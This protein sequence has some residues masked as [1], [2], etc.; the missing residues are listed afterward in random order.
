MSR[1][2]PINVV[3]AALFA[4]IILTFSF[5]F[6]ISAMTDNT[7]ASE[8]VTVAD[9]M[10]F[11]GFGESYYC[12]DDLQMLIGNIEYWL[13][14][15]I[16]S[17]DIILGENGFLFDAGTEDNGYNYL[18]D[19]I[20]DATLSGTEL[21]ALK[22]IIDLR[23][24]VYESRGIDYLLVV[25]PNAQTVYSDYMPDYMGELSENTRLS[26]LTK[27][28]EQ[29]GCDYF[30]NATE[31]LLTAKTYGK[32]LYNN[33][34]NSLNSL[35]EWY[36]YDAVRQRLEQLYGIKGSQ[37][38]VSSLDLYTR[39]TDGKELA[40]RAGLSSVIF[41]ETLSLSNSAQTKYTVSSYYGTMVHSAITE[42]YKVAGDD[43]VVLLEFSSEWDRILL[44]P[45][46]SNTYSQVTYKDNHQFSR[47]AVEHMNPTVVVQFVH[48]HE[49]YDLLDSNTLLTYSSGLQVSVQ[50]DVTAPPMLIAQSSIDEN[51]VCVAG[52]TEYGAL[53]K[54][55]VD[56][57]I[58]RNDYAVG[59]L[60]FI[61]VDLGERES[62]RVKIT[63]QAQ[64]KK[65]SDA[66]E[67]TL[68]RD[69][70]AKQKTVAVGTNSELYSSDYS[71]LSF[72][73]DEQMLSV[74]E[75][76][77]Q[78]VSNVKQLTG[79][80]TEYIYLIVPDKLAVYPDD[81]PEE[82]QQILPTLNKYR[83]VVRG[84]RESAGMTVI[85]LTKEMRNHTALARLYSQTD[86]L[87]TGFGAYVGYH[88][89][90]SRVA[91]RFSAVQVHELI[92][93]MAAT[94]QNV[95]GELVSRL[96][97]DGAVIS[98]SYLT[99]QRSFQP[100]ARFE[101][102]GDGVLDLTQAFI[103]YTDNRDLPV[104][105]VVRDEYGTEMLENIAE[106]FSKMIVLRE[107]EFT[108]SDELIAEIKPDYIINIRCNGE[109]S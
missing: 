66:I 70:G 26:V 60:F 58:I 44:M 91:E 87:W 101:H 49:I 25:V 3:C 52:E 7:V 81:A 108:V 1:A 47:L 62:V 54:V 22:S 74:R 57:E 89:L 82:L 45:Y 90:A 5:F 105:I 15:S 59:E 6:G 100:Q 73:S 35:G 103:S 71:W 8:T 97:L 11:S 46:F 2:K 31:T 18:R 86:V 30:F 65:V 102:S 80:D 75:G 19:Y 4:G 17:P 50:D 9:D 29:V 63:A 93:F 14:G 55:S 104:A 51:T 39:S 33:T 72:L 84:V 96:G 94:E 16:D 56:G 99:L 21:K 95:G 77:E 83:D 43:N 41:N 10:T 38:G 106:H 79:K 109:L 24:N 40:R 37:V 28:L 68:Y 98:E 78:K 13:F 64:G 48:E 34:E 20:G 61:P 27:Y 32:P 92:D 88:S 53:M 23:K 85:D 36:L 12:N 107:G 67:L 69:E 42:E 76:L